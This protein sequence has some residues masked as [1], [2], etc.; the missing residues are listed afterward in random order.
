MA[1]A[2]AEGGGQIVQSCDTASKEGLLNDWS[3][4]ITRSSGDSR[5]SCS[6]SG[7][8]RSRLAGVSAMIEAGRVL[9]PFEASWLGEFKHELLAFPS[10]R[11]DDQVDALSQMLI[12]VDR[13]QRLDST[14]IAAPIIISIDDPDRYW[15]SVDSLY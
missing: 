8:E 6:T 5:C 9:L 15:P 13:Q 11:H 7:D 2:R 3:V 10:S 1:Q 4:C 12:W 14:P